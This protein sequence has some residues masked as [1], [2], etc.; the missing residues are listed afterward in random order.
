MM[1]NL[2]NFLK[3]CQLMQDRQIEN[4]EIDSI[5]NEGRYYY[6]ATTFLLYRIWLSL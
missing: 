2:K 3:E 1:G 5:P 4:L 6:T